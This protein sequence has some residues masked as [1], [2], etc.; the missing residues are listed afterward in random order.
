MTSFRTLTFYLPIPDKTLSPNARC[1][2]AVKAKAVK[3]ARAAAKIEACRVLG[4]SGRPAPRWA[5]AKYTARLYTLPANR[6]RDPDN[7]IASLK[8]YLDGIA[9]AQIVAKDRDLW[10][11]R[12][13]F[14]L[15]TRMPRVEIVITAE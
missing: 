13:E 12:P 15:C 14:H 7:F 10:P 8:S 3:A 11:E 2:W 1:H 9:D 6:V 4:D 5:K